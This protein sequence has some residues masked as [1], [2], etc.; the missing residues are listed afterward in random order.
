MPVESKNL[1][2][3]CVDGFFRRREDHVKGDATGVPDD[4]ESFRLSE[5]A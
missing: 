2:T 4:R 5:S 1:Q 3:L